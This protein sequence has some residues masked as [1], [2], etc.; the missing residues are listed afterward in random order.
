ML[1]LLLHDL[2]SWL[3]IQDIKKSLKA[4]KKDRFKGVVKLVHPSHDT[5]TITKIE[6]NNRLNETPHRT[7]EVRRVENNP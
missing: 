2:I 1:R 3:D 5:Y 7:S 4:P 6:G